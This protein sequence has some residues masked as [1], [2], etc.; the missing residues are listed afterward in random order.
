MNL[1]PGDGH[2]TLAIVLVGVNSN[3]EPHRT[4]PSPCTVV[5]L[6]APLTLYAAEGCAAMQLLTQGEDENEFVKFAAHAVH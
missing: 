5:L 4:T 6:A 2:D 1:P 3:P